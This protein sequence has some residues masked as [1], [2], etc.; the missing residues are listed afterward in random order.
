MTRSNGPYDQAP[1]WRYQ[2]RAGHDQ[3]GDDHQQQQWQPGQDDHDKSQ[4]FA[5]P[6]LPREQDYAAYQPAPSL[7]RLQ[8]TI[9]S[10][11]LK[12]NLQK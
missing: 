3:A 7:Q 5:V 4:Q 11:C 2:S 9:Q 8:E 6:S 1:N 12:S 10:H